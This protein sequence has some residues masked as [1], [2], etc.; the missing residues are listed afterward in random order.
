M[1]ISYTDQHF[2]DGKERKLKGQ[3]N[4]FTSATG[5]IMGI[6]TMREKQTKNTPMPLLNS[7]PTEACIVLGFDFIS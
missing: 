4:S 7:N 3:D 5:I 2:K 6:I 1:T